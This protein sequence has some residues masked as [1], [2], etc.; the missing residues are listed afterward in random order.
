MAN[1]TARKDLACFYEDKHGEIHQNCV[2]LKID[3][4]K[5]KN[6]RYKIK[7]TISSGTEEEGNYK[8]SHST[9][10]VGLV[11]LLHNRLSNTK[12]EHDMQ[13]EQYLELKEEERRG[14][15]ASDAEKTASDDEAGNA[16]GS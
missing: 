7:Y 13:K 3:T 12:E 2:I 16:S 8:M 11:R 5:K 15:E 10:H 9:V 1:D 6:Q 4:K 14:A